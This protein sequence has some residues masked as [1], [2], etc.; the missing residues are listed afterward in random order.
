MSIDTNGQLGLE[1][2][3]HFRNVIFMK[4][5]QISEGCLDFQ[6]AV[7]SHKQYNEGQG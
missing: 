4:N 2:I 1:S 7:S 3:F 5:I 6:E